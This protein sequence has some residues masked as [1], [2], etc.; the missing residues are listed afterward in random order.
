MLAR[1]CHLN[2]FPEDRLDELMMNLFSLIADQVRD[3]QELF[4][5]EGKIMQTLLNGGYD[6]HDADAALTLMQ[7]LVQK[8][9]ENFFSPD[10][11]GCPAGIRTMNSEERRRLTPEAFAFAVKL[12]HLG[13]LTENQREDILERAM[14][15]SRGR[16][17]L[18]EVK[19]LTAFL[20]FAGL[21]DREDDDP[22]GHPAIRRTAW[23]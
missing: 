11:A 1:F 19:A 5:D 3:K 20:L 8:Q 21:H 13:I 23:N 15:L 9:A 12:T 4:D 7:T 18:D 2:S 16:A 22:S 10:Q 14:G 6:L 17:E